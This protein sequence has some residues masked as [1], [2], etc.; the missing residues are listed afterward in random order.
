[1]SLLLVACDINEKPLSIWQHSANGSSAAAISYDGNFAL[2]SGYNEPTAWWDL[3]KNARLFNWRMSSKEKNDTDTVQ[4]VSI[5]YDAKRAVT[6]SLTNFAIWDTKSGQ[7]LGFYKAPSTIRSI[8]ISRK[9]RFVLLGVAEGK[10]IFMSLKTGRRLEFLGHIL[11]ARKT[12][13]D[14]T[15]SPSW[16]GINSVDLSANGKYA[17]SGGDDHAAILWDT[18]SGQQIYLWPHNNRVHYVKFSHDGKLAF[19]ASRQA[20]AYIWDLSTGKMV[21][22]LKLKSREWIISSARF[23]PNNKQLLTG[24]PGRD[25]KLWQT[26]TGSLIKSFKVKKRF[27]TKASGAVV[28][29]VA[30]TKDG[31]ALSEASSGYGEKWSLKP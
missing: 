15:L 31:N 28:L 27:S 10:A 22:K 21:S 8:A 11:H 17:I 4:V 2:V 30:F 16:V 6:A 29:D 18:Q 24:S 1:M 26:A 9:A 5:G 7:N 14:P 23:S 20:E 19:T 25:L 13:Q 3:N 12:I